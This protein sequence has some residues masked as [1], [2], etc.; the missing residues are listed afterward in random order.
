MELRSAKTL[1]ARAELSI[2]TIRALARR[3]AIR[4]FKCGRSVRFDPDDLV[5]LMAKEGTAR[6]PRKKRR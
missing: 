4:K 2:S 6:R 3:G 1:A 5:K